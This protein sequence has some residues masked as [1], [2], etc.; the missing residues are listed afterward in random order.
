MSRSIVSKLKATTVR[1]D[2][3]EIINRVAYGKEHVILTR[4]GKD[5]AALVPADELD[6]FR[7]VIE[8]LEDELDIAEAKKRLANKKEI[9]IPYKILRKEMGLK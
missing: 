5:L 8:K 7:S 2:F 3:S 4:R 9:P 6:L 1:D